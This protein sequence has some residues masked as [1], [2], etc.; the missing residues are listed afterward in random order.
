MYSIGDKVRV[1]DVTTAI[2]KKLLNKVSTIVDKP[3]PGLITLEILPEMKGV[4]G[5][6][7][8]I[9]PY[10]YWNVLEPTV[11]HAGK[12]LVKNKKEE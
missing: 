10:T 2:N 11:V 5:W 4:K 12:I 1:V 9:G 8:V 6:P 7:S 3:A